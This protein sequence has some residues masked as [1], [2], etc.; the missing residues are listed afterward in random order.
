MCAYLHNYVCLSVGEDDD[1]DIVI[2]KLIGH[3][4]CELRVRQEW[5]SVSRTAHFMFDHEILHLPRRRYTTMIIT[6][7][8]ALI[9]AHY[10]YSRDHIERETRRQ[11][12]RWREK[13]IER[14]V[15]MKGERERGIRFISSSKMEHLNECQFYISALRPDFFKATM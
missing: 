8:M 4:F 14:E 9:N 11:T 13:E 3:R 1:V 12:E 7:C 6:L 2:S 10:Y 5:A 15:E